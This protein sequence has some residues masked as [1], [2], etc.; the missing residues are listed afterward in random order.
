VDPPTAQARE[1]AEPQPGTEQHQHMIP[2]EQRT[3]CEQP[4]GFLGRVGPP[5]GLPQDLLR[6][7]PAL[8]RRHPAQRIPGDGAFV[9]G[10][11]EDAEQD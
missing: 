1:L 3:R 4:T 6:V 11:L 8:G 2:P 10:Q 9:L 7:D 5:L